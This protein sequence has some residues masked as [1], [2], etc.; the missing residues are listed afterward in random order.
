MEEQEVF[1]KLMKKQVEPG[2]LFDQLRSMKIRPTYENAV[3]FQM[4]RKA[5]EGDLSAAKYILGAV[6]EPQQEECPSWDLSE[7]STAQLQK[8]LEEDYEQP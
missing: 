4:V 1:R 5:A 6:Q 8:W 7:C 3:C 2:P